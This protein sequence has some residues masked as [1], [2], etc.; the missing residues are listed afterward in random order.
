LPRIFTG[1][2]GVQVIERFKLCADPRWR[3]V[4]VAGLNVI[5]LQKPV[6]QCKYAKVFMNA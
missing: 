2:E 3:G 5:V 4:R 1:V 6:V